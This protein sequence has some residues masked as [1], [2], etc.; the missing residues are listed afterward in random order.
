MSHTIWS[1]LQ[2]FLG[3]AFAAV[4]I[5]VTQSMSGSGL[6]DSSISIPLHSFPSAPTSASKVSASKSAAPKAVV[7]APKSKIAYIKGKYLESL[8]IQ[9]Q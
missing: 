1:I 8:L 9:A 3:A 2:G 6:L 7:S 5:A 4:G